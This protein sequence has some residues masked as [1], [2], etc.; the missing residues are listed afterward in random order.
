MR[1]GILT[2]IICFGIILELFWSYFGIK[3]AFNKC[4][5]ELKVYGLIIGIDVQ[6]TI[7]IL[8]YEPVGGYLRGTM[9]VKNPKLI[10]LNFD[11]KNSLLKKVQ[12]V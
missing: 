9:S 1:E 7:L 8:V 4:L 3:T 6:L 5:G 2:G 12:G 11:T 10:F